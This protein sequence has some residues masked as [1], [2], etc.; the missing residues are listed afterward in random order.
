MEPT[1]RRKVRP[2]FAWALTLLL[3]P[4]VVLFGTGMNDPAVRWPS[5]T[6]PV[7]I[8]FAWVAPL[9]LVWWL[10]RQGLYLSDAVVAALAFAVGVLCFSLGLFVKGVP[11]I[12]VIITVFLGSGC[13][14]L[15]IDIGR[16][17]W[18]GEVP[19]PADRPAPAAP[20]F[21]PPPPPR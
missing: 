16:A 6:A 19:P 5:L 18:R 12:A 11:A 10:V 4:I 17:R 3:G 8:L 14:A 15:T 9:V 2:V 21:P 13:I 7:Y 1:A 20:A